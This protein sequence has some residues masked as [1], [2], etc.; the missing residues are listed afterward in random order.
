ML[1]KQADTLNSNYRINF[2][3][4]GFKRFLQ[5]IGRMVL[6]FAGSDYCIEVNRYNIMTK[7]LLSKRFN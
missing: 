2:L 1:C 5:E 6:Y 3:Q 7:M 4:S